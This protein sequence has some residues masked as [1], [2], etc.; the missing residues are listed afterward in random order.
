MQSGVA[1]AQSLASD[2]DPSLQPK[3]ARYT[4]YINVPPVT[5][6]RDAVEG[7]AE[8]IQKKTAGSMQGGDDVLTTSRLYV[9]LSSVANL[10]KGA[11]S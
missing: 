6:T 10:K 8:K 2:R 3:R 1:T 11:S 4:R 7:K 5:T 9:P